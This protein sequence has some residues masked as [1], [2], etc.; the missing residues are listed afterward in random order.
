MYLCVSV[1]VS[2]SASPQEMMAVINALLAQQGRLREGLNIFVHG[3]GRPT[4]S[5]SPSRSAL[6][7][8]LHHAGQ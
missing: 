7:C 5:C 4:D 1:T 2:V 3:G 8:A 6:C